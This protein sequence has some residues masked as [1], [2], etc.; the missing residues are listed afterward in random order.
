MD[1]LNHGKYIIF[2]RYLLVRKTKLGEK[3]ENKEIKYLQILIILIS[4]L[5]FVLAIFFFDY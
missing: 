1:Y 4:N 3:K 5:I 2:K